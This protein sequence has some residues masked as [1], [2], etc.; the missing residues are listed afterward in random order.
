MRKPAKHPRNQ[1]TSQRLKIRHNKERNKKNHR[2]K[3][4][5]NHKKKNK[6]NHR[7]KKR[8]QKKMKKRLTKNCREEEKTLKNLCKTKNPFR[9]REGIFFSSHVRRA[10]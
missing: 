4:K 9:C 2:R 10:K 5:K 8:K 6:K 7:K 3:N 1:K